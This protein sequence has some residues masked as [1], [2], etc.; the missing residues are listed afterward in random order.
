MHRL[1]LYSDLGALLVAAPFLA[2]LLAGF[3][4]LDALLSAPRCNRPTAPATGFDR[5]GR[6]FFTDPDGRPW[7]P[8]RRK[9][10][11]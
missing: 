11:A 5:D 4:R 2:L 6:I 3:F 10:P 1:F 9:G 8:G 7:Y